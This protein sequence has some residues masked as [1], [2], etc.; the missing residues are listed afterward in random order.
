MA[1]GVADNGDTDAQ[2]R[3]KFALRNRFGG[4]VGAF[5][6]HVRLKFTQ[7]RMDVQLV[8]NYHVIH[9]GQRGGQ[10]G[11]RAFGEDRAPFAFQRPRARVGID[12][13]YQHVP[14]GARGV[15]VAHVSH[16]QQIE[17]SVS[18]HNSAPG[19]AMLLE[20]PVQARTGKDFRTSV[21]QARDKRKAQ[22]EK[23]AA[24][25]F[26]QCTVSQFAEK[27]LKPK[28]MTLELC[29]ELKLRPPKTTL[30]RQLFNRAAKPSKSMRTLAAEG[31]DSPAD[32]LLSSKT[33]S[34]A[35]L[36][37]SNA[38]GHI[39]ERSGNRPW[40][41]PR[42]D[43]QGAAMVIAHVIG[44]LQHVPGEHRDHFF[45]RADAAAGNQLLDAR[46][47]GG[48]SRLL[49]AGFRRAR[50]LPSRPQSPARSR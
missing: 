7:Q 1:L 36:F 16:V 12:A 9:R 40:A 50:S 47:G 34:T 28:R 14:L 49:A 5:C 33:F 26:R 46:H 27:G 23:S 21:H 8:E 32:Q 2:P 39:A 44:I 17:D 11:T 29:R 10:A 6:V 43:C 19:P 22:G 18:Q 13:H 31:S 45:R 38:L 24:A 4:V 48:G 41:I 3:G 30:F 25:D 42:I 37:A 35:A 20:H 15:Q